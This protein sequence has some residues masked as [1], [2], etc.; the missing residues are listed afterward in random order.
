MERRVKISDLKPG[1]EVWTPNAGWFRVVKL[2][3]V[4]SV[5][6]AK[7]YNYET[8]SPSA[9][10]CGRGGLTVKTRG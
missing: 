9:R 1:M 3:R 5:N 4:F 7:M 10:L 8:T 6:T 2:I